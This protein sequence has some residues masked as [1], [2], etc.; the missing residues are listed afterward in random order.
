MS[1]KVKIKDQDEKWSEYKLADGTTLRV[2][3]IIAPKVKRTEDFTDSGNPV[4]EVNGTRA[5]V[6]DSPDYL[7]ESE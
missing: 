3:P 4:Y 7:K 2:K 6:A 1:E 5:I